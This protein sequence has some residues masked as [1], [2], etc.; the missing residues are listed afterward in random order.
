[1]TK[2]K[3][4]SHR[5]GRAAEDRARLWL[6]G[7]HAVAA[8][9]ANPRRRCCRLLVTRAAEESLSAR[10]A[11]APAARPSLEIRDRRDIE[12]LLPKDAVHQGVALLADPLPAVS[13][14]SVLAGLAPGGGAVVCLDRVTDP[15]NVGAVLRSAAAFSA[16]AVVQP[17]DQAP[18][19]TGTLAKAASGSLEIVPLVRVVNLAR[20][21][22]T[23]KEAGFWCVGL[24]PGAERTLAA[25]ELDDRVALVLGSEGGGLRRLTSEACDL[26]VRIPVS[27]AVQSLNLSAT[28]AIALY[29]LSHRRR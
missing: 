2:R 12:R 1:M 19:A 4:S 28:A 3:A 14:E 16:A 26:R 6:F 25:A 9:L 23:L 11:A 5:G 10:L 13:L 7:T 21:L 27:A 24:E 22:R 15:Q 17:R 29:E 8:A 20:A 18:T